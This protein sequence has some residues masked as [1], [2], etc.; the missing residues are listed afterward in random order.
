MRASKGS[1]FWWYLRVSEG[2]TLDQMREAGF[3]CTITDCGYVAKYGALEFV[4]HVIAN[5]DMCDDC[6]GC[7]V[8]NVAYLHGDSTVLEW[9]IE[10]YNLEFYIYQAQII[11]ATHGQLLPL[12]TM[13]AHGIVIVPDA[14]EA[15]VKNQ[16]VN[17][18][19]WYITSFPETNFHHIMELAVKYNSSDILDLCM[20]TSS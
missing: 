14:L 17:I 15:A 16:R 7:D 5:D 18:V 2:K 13:H 11:A 12:E 1:M 9:L 10:S 6:D 3:H 19:E 20:K 8:I 4:Q